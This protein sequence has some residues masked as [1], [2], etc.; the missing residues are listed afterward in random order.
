[1][2]PSA[3]MRG[4][5]A[6][7][8]GL[9]LCVAC[10]EAPL[11]AGPVKPPGVGV[12]PLRWEPPAAT[13]VLL[14]DDV[15]PLRYR[16]ELD[17]DPRDDHFSGRT[18]IAV[19]I[20]T[21][22]DHVVLH[23]RDLEVKSAAVVQGDK[24]VA[25]EVRT[26]RAH[27]AKDADEELV[28]LLPEW[29][30]PGAAEIVIEY[31]APFGSLWGLFR[32][33]DGPR[34]FAFTQ[35][36]STFARRMFPSFDEPRHKTP[37]DVVIDVP[38]TMRAFANTA[39]T[40]E[41]VA[42][43]GK[44]R[45]VFETSKPMPT[46]LVAIAVGEL[47][48][49]EG[50][51]SPTPI[52]LLAAPGRAKLGTDA[53]DAA[54]R[55][56]ASLESYFGI[57]YP[58]GKLDLAAVPNFAVGA[59]E[60]AGLVTFREELLLAGAS[61]PAILRRRMALV[62]AHELAH[63]WFGNL[64]T[65]KWWDDIW[66][67]EGFATWMQSK[68][69]DDAWSGF[70]AR[71]E[72]VLSKDVAMRVDVLPSSRAVR[73]KVTLADDIGQSAGWSAYQKGS[74]VLTM[75]EA[76]TGEDTFRGAIRAYV[77][78]EANRSITS[79][80]LFAALD[81]KTKKPVSRVAKTFLD[82]PGVPLVR[83]SMTCDDKTRAPIAV[84]LDVSKLGGVADATWAVPVCL[85]VEG[86][87]S[88]RCTLLE[89]PQ[90]SIEL[91]RCPAYVHPNAGETGYYRYDL[92][93]GSWNKLERS[94]SRLDETERAGLLLDTWALVLVGQRG[95]E[96]VLA[97][98]DSIDWKKE[99]SR[100]VVEAAISVLVEI[101]KTLVDASV[102]ERFAKLVHRVL[103]PTRKRL[104][105]P[106]P[107]ARE[108]AD[109]ALLRASVLGALHDLADDP[110]VARALQAAGR[111][112]IDDPAQAEAL[113]GPD[114]GPLAARVAVA[115]DPEAVRLLDE[116]KLLAAKSPDHR[117]GLTTAIASRREPKALVAALDLLR[118]GSIRAGDLR[119]VK[120]AVLGRQASRTV[121][122][123]WVS[124]HFDE[125]AG[126]VGGPSTL[127]G[128]L[129]AACGDEAAAIALAGLVETKLD[130]LE[131]ARRDWEEGTEAR[132]R[133]GDV[134]SRERPAFADA[135]KK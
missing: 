3:A 130:K 52:G 73:Q 7:L 22:T 23:G 17:V 35:L 64:V 20:E 83:V 75:L 134:R 107:G 99:T 74:S 119:H 40:S 53:L 120:N 102:R 109:V 77:A 96:H 39:A 32:V 60:N 78:A 82:Q 95:T 21:A 59:M 131:G 72:R 111:K 108:A 42:P 2:I 76:W 56:L 69:C 58:Y 106:K 61:S 104:G 49:V 45:V 50:A 110:A 112:Y 12:E 118:S 91:D 29:L 34:T 105:M 27:G 38:S 135:L 115:T 103:D 70:G 51:R 127:V 43:S 5:F 65:M 113:V 79:A 44:K 28:L 125:L 10:T 24:R 121:F 4:S 6:G 62:M 123:A 126:K 9:S 25:A 14:P 133:C 116:A 1:V 57:P 101:D 100:L 97:L 129:G 26:R 68:V 19:R 63:Q 48:H 88:P 114:L 71:G 8:L 36:E 55:S 31:A 67:N 66:L 33:K 54:L 11:P 87:T 92:D 94:F 13:S 47:E 122:F 30:A 128:P 86:E 98:L 80:E 117:V 124:E 84:R 16:L 46:Y 18:T 41:T 89:G 81:D 15:I 93:E 90:G 37:F 85:R 132:M